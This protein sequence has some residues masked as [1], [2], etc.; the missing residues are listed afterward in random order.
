MT[1]EPTKGP[2]PVLLRCKS[3]APHKTQPR[4]P[5]MALES[6]C[7]T[8]KLSP[9]QQ[10]RE[11]TVAQTEYCLSRHPLALY[12]HL[13]GSISQELFREVVGV[14]DPEMLLLSEE[15]KVGVEQECLALSEIQ[16]QLEGK[17]KSKTKAKRS[18]KRKG[19]KGKD[20]YTWFSKQEVAAREREARLNYVP[21]L[22]QNVKEATQEFCRWFES[23]S[24]PLVSHPSFTQRTSVV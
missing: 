5:Q 13:A 24:S 17:G 18:H 3:E 9:M 12:P 7:Y 6:R 14:L 21:P 11:E 10:A 8:S 19:S 23:L 20:P 4:A 15:E 16:T 2:A 1:S 22:D